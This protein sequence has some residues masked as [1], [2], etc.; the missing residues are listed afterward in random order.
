[1][2]RLTWMVYLGVMATTVV[3]PRA[4]V[5]ETPQAGTI[6]PDDWPTVK[7][8]TRLALSDAVV[9]DDHGRQVTVAPGG[10]KRPQATQWVEFEVR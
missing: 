6:N 1:M 3:V 7:A 5:P 2:R 10:V 9:V 8:G 4:Q